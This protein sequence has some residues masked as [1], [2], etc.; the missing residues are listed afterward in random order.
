MLLL[1][2]RTGGTAMNDFEITLGNCVDLTI[3]QW[4]ED[5]QDPEQ[6]DLF[7]EEV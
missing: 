3:D 7:E 4:I 6:I 1:Q 2:I 5:N